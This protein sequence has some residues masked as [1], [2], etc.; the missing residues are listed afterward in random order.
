MEERVAVTVICWAT[1][2]VVD[3]LCDGGAD[4]AAAVC[5]I[6]MA[7]KLGSHAATISAR[8]RR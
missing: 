2:L 8:T 5:E 6:A 1:E 4:C 3:G 7:L